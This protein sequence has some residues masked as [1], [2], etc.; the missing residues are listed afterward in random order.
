MAYSYQVLSTSNGFAVEIYKDDK[1]LIY[2]P[3]NPETGE[4][5]KSEDEA[6][7][8][9]EPVVR[10]YQLQ[11]FLENPPHL[12]IS[13]Q[14]PE[15]GEEKKIATVGEPIKVKVELYYPVGE[16]EKVYAPISGKYIVPYYA[17][18]VQAG[19]VV[20][21]IENGVGEGTIKVN[22]SGIF[23]IKLDKVLNAETMQQPNPLPV[24]DSNPRIAIVE[25]AE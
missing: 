18:D 12:K 17:D 1:L 11:E 10:E 3:I 20:I 24:L 4:P 7:A 5:F 9:A 22:K 2:Q 14:D 23:E 16:G 8:W 19:S 21:G 13:F 25:P 15:T 6:R